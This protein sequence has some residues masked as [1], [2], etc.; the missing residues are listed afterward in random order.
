MSRLLQEADLLARKAFCADGIGLA[1]KDWTA[2]EE[3]EG[4][5]HKIPLNDMIHSRGL[6]S[7]FIFSD[8]N[9]LAWV[10]A[11]AFF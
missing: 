10:L 11:L 8:S 3:K 5:G 9:F 6:Q 7:S 1:R 4:G 2:K